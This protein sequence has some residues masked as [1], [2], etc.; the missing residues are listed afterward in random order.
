MTDHC[1]DFDRYNEGVFDRV[2]G[3]GQRVFYPQLTMYRRE[4]A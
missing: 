4:A 1:Y 2:T 3:D